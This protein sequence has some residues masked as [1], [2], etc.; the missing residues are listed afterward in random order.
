[1]QIR[2]ASLSCWLPW[3]CVWMAIW[4]DVS[5]TK[6]GDVNWNQKSS[7]F[8]KSWVDNVEWKFA[9]QVENDVVIQRNSRCSIL[10]KQT[11]T[12]VLEPDFLDLDGSRK[13]PMK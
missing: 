2:G 13:R 11:T 4:C 12:Q 7:V 5:L 9:A 3:Y 10:V 6:R 1:M 8:C